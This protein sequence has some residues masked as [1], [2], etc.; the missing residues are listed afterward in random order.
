[1]LS[2]LLWRCPPPKVHSYHHFL[3]RHQVMSHSNPALTTL[4]TFFFFFLRQGLALSPRLECRAW[5]WLTAASTSQTQVVLLLQPVAGTTG[6]CHHSWL[7]L[8]FFGRDRTSLCCPSWSQTLDLSVL[9]GLNFHNICTTFSL[10]SVPLM[11]IEVYSMSLL[12]WIVLQWI[13][14]C[15]YLNNISRM[16]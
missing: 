15:M 4:F 1:M 13:Y 12:L 8:S 7:I 6:A 3:L 14:A 11:G 10:F 2:V 5:S 9:L 16:I